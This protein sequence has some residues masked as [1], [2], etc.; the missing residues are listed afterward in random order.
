M[1][2]DAIGIDMNLGKE[3]RE[4]ISKDPMRRTARAREHARRSERERARAQRGE[5]RTRGTLERKPGNGILGQVA[6]RCR[7]AG[8]R[9]HGFERG[10]CTFESLVDNKGVHE[11]RN[12]HQVRDA[13]E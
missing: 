1:Y 12:A 4:V 2:Q 9:M 11:A 5:L 7:R 3:P 10:A 13:R 6:N 8:H